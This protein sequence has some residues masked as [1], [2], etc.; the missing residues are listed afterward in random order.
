LLK[1]YRRG[2]TMLLTTHYMDEADVLGDRIGIMSRGEL[3]CIGS[4]TFLKRHFGAGYKLLLTMQPGALATRHSSTAADPVAVATNKSRKTLGDQALVKSILAF[5]TE[6]V[7]GASFLQSESSAATLSF[8]LPFDQVNAFS[9][10]FPLLDADLSSFDIV[11]YG[12]TITSLEEVFLRVGGDHSLASQAAASMDGAEKA[13]GTGSLDM[14]H[15]QE[16]IEVQTS[17][18]QRFVARGE[19]PQMLIQIYGL[20]R[21][22]L[23]YALHD[24]KRAVPMIL[25]PPAAALAAFLCN[26]YGQF[27]TV[28]AL[29][30]S[31]ATALVV[32]AGYLPMVALISEHVVAERVSRLRNV[33]TVMGCDVKSY[34]IGTLLGDFTLY[35]ISALGIVITALGCAL[36]RP[37]PVSDDEYNTNNL[38]TWVNDGRLFILL[39]LFGFQLISFSYFCSHFFNSPK[40]AIAFMPF[41][42]IAL[43]F[44]PTIFVG[45]FWY[46]LGPLGADLI[47]FSGPALFINML[48]GIA[49]CSPQGTLCMGLLRIGRA[50]RGMD[51]DVCSIP[52]FW[53]TCLIMILESVLYMVGTYRV[54]RTGF[55]PIAVHEYTP[56]EDQL[57][58][59]DIDV[60]DERNKILGMAADEVLRP[61]LSL[62]LA[63]LR[64]LFPAKQAG[65]PPLEAVKSLCV[66]LPR[67]ELFGL[68]GANGAGKTTAISMIMRALYPNAGDVHIEGHSVLT[69]FRPAAKHLGV[70]TQ[71]NTLWDRLTCMDH[72]YLFARI[73]GVPG[74]QVHNLVTQTIDQM[75]LT[76]YKNKLAMQLSGGMKRKLCVAIALI[77]D[78]Q[79][80]MLDEPSAGL[81]PVSRRNLWDV[82]IKTMARRSV[83]LTTHSMEEAEALCTRIGIM[84]KGQIRALGTPQH[85]KNKFGSG[86]EII[87]KL[88]P[89]AGPIDDP[90]R[91]KEVTDF[92]LSLF[93]D[94]AMLSNNGGLLTYRVPGH[95]IQVGVAFD[96]LEKNKAS[97]HLSDYAVAQPTLEQVFVRTVLQYSEGERPEAEAELA[98]ALHEADSETAPKSPD[99]PDLEQG[100]A[101]PVP[102]KQAL[103]RESSTGEMHPDQSIGVRVSMGDLASDK[104]Q[105]DVPEH[106]IEDYGL[107]T[108]W[109]GLDR[110]SHRFMAISTGLFMY[111]CYI[112]IVTQRIGFV[113]FPFIVAF[114]FCAAGC[115][116]CCCMIPQVNEGDDD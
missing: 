27:G 108:H 9:A 7:P 116:G 48:R 67:G 113:F 4:S 103:S 5:I 70:V 77:G 71:H 37:V 61:A 86:Y 29:E 111:L 40:F 30:A 100:V 51:S 97:L 6:H 93:N 63:G 101:P 76:P 17:D 54:D 31:I 38:T 104:E 66:G 107:R 19:Q 34:W 84:V 46:G 21:K 75:E 24:P 43:L 60:V 102:L 44:I 64:K 28:G 69:D 73:R 57:T 89:A 96:A 18:S 87:I 55:L 94:A 78:P 3:Q 59:L 33:L 68:L 47:A 80:V 10:F 83:V 105:S 112:I 39:A 16:E 79:V 74:D 98:R 42:C 72:L 22:R 32:A 106:T 65:Q 88:D 58:D 99:D 8:V 13:S 12:V 20:W 91:V 26:I 85:L 1:A 81:D 52:E 56:P 36:G 23:A 14:D 45:L 115:A 15:G 110:R 35:A 95:S 62:R 49:V 90:D 82:L 92:V 41:F 53:I 25:L 114:F 11:G 50:C 2:R 109:L